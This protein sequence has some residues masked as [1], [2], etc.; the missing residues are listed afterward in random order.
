MARTTLTKTEAPGGYPSL[1]LTADGIDV[2]MAAADATNKNQFISTGKELVLAQNTGASAATVTVTSVA[3]AYSR[4]GDIET[5]SVDPDEIAVL[6]P[7]PVAGW[8][9][10][11]GMVYL[12]ASSTDIQFGVIVLP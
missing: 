7:F 8:K 5:Y 6:G 10:S 2:T 1:P 4:T 9:Q 12:E 3:D 11:D